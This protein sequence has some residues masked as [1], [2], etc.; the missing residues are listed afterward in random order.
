MSGP[1]RAGIDEAGVSPIRLADRA[2][3][4]V[5][6][7]RRELEM[8][9]VGHQ[10]TGPHLDR[11]L[12]AALGEQVAVKRVVGRLEEDLLAS[13]PALRHVMGKTWEDDT[14]DARH[15]SYREAVRK[16]VQ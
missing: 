14:A 4:P 15:V 2:R 6:R 13:F 11:R 5:R 16:L 12:A 10:A 9:G 7:S 8:D 1:S 3:A